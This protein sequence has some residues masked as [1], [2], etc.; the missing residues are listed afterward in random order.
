MFDVARDQLQGLSNITET[1]LAAAKATLR[2][3]V[4]QGLLT[5]ESQLEESLKNM[6][7]FG[8]VVHPEYLNW[9]ETVTTQDVQNA[10][11]SALSQT[12]TLVL[13]GGQISGVKTSL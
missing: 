7:T 4:L 5:P 12:P 13:Q 6:R 2:R 9:I 8:K 10:V 11:A 3:R 1:E